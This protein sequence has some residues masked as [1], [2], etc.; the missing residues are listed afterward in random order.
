MYPIDIISVLLRVYDPKT[1]K[2]NLS[3]DDHPSNIQEV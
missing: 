2:K 3:G 1:C